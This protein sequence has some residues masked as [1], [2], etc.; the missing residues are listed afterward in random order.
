MNGTFV[1]W[2]YIC[3]N[4]REKNFELLKK[5]R[6]EIYNLVIAHKPSGDYVA[7]KSAHPSGVPN[8]LHRPSMSK[9]YNDYDPIG[10]CKRQIER[11]KFYKY[12]V[13][14]ILGFGL[15]MH[16]AALS[17]EHEIPSNGMIFLVEP[18][19][20]I[21]LLALEVVDCTNLIASKS[22]IFLLDGME[23]D[24]IY[25]KIYDVFLISDAKYYIKAVNFIENKFSLRMNQKYIFMIIDKFKSALRECLLHYGNDPS[26]SLV[27]ISQTFLNIKEIVEYPG[28]KN[29]KDAFKGK[30]GVVVA[31]G[32]SLHKNVHLLEKIKDNVVIVSADSSLTILLNMGI[33][34]HF[35]TCLERIIE[36]SKLF[37]NIRK[38]D[39]DDEV[40][41]AACPVVRPETYQNFKGNRRICVYRSFAT[42]EWLNIERGILNIGPSSANMAFSILKYM[43]CTNIILIGQDLAFGEDDSS[44]AEGTHYGSRQHEDKSIEADL[45][46]RITLEG[47]YK[48]KITSTDTWLR[49]LKFYI[50]DISEY[51]GNTINATEGG[52]KI[53]GTKLMSFQEAIDKY[54]NMDE[55]IKVLETVKSLCHDISINEIAQNYK[56]VYE[57]A[58][59]GVEYCKKLKK[60]Y[61]NAIS[62][63]AI[64]E[65]EIAHKFFSN[66]PYDEKLAENIYA[67]VMNEIH[68]SFAERDF[69][70]IVMHYVQPVLIKS[71]VDINSMSNTLPYGI[72]RCSRELIMTANLAKTIIKLNERML[73]M[74][75]QMRDFVKKENLDNEPIKSILEEMDT[76]FGFDVV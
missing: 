75:E 4:T 36:T 8:I 38:E 33:K 32:P 21:F 41:L 59:N 10:A 30:T 68:S 31:T 45:E 56:S 49:F 60:R 2:I 71:L 57:K 27:G 11:M 18:N 51:D 66:E 43:G 14:V 53:H 6:P 73:P 70:L 61:E 40:Y 15:G 39:V 25:L 16:I 55:D 20:D 72:E 17:Q 13:V 28:I 62:E 65:K 46:V 12:N 44:H 58:S 35:V 34:P 54:V 48:P 69:Y 52:A 47:N 67:N 22:V 1:A 42:F 24:E 50:K 19:L 74:L 7:I 5:H 3:M 64:F 26:D 29:L 9:M 76:S 37:E 63:A 23:P